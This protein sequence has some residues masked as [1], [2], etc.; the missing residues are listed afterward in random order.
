MTETT[1]RETRFRQ[2]FLRARDSNVVKRICSFLYSAYFPPIFAVIVLLSALFGLEYAY[3]PIVA[4]LFV[5]INLFC[6]DTKPAMP[7]VLLAVFGASSKHAVGNTDGSNFI[8]TQ[9][10]IIFMCVLVFFLLL[11]IGFRLV[12]YK[13][14]RACFRKTRVLPGIVG[15]IA[16]FFFNGLSV[17]DY[18]IGNLYTALL[19]LVGYLV[20]YLYFSGTY[21]YQKGDAQYLAKI[22]VLA[23]LLLTVQLLQVY[24]LHFKPGMLL[25]GA[26][27]LR[28]VLGCGVNNMIGIL[29]VIMMPPCFYL[30]QTEKAGWVYYL[31]A[32]LFVVAAYFTLSRAALAVGVPVFLLCVI[33]SCVKK[34]RRKLYLI[35]TAGFVAALAAVAVAFHFTGELER[36][37]E[38]FKEAGISDRGRFS[39][40]KEDIELF[41]KYPLF[42]GGFVAKAGGYES[43]FMLYSHNTIM[44]MLGGCGLVGLLAYLYHRYTTL[45]LLFFKPSLSR[46]FFGV[47]LVV[48]VLTGLFDNVFFYT[49]TG[50][51]YS[52]MLLI[53][54]HE[55]EREQAERETAAAA[56]S[57]DGGTDGAE[58][59]QPA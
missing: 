47:T 52:V 14:I 38:F 57:T 48:Y 56:L 1:A 28:I 26:W 24:I 17:T 54:E 51:F 34:E 15:M 3:F 46:L 55:L 50:F 12:F 27:K 59:E 43:F 44:Q 25:D 23:G 20:F 35:M 5:F 29:L 42:G 53:G 49:Y 18:A 7:V 13:R 39:I 22:F 32:V 9:P 58:P 19:L 41:L 30:M 45:K 36:L 4:V 8:F 40:W 37:F 2:G 6:A 31:F 16:V 10:F 11:S 33:Y 21:H